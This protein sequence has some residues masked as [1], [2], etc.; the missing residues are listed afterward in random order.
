MAERELVDAIHHEVYE[1]LR[2]CGVDDLT[3]MRCAD[4]ACETL[5]GRFG[6]NRHYMP[7][8]DKEPRNLRIAADL[9][10]VQDPKA[11]ATKHGVSVSTVKRAAR[12]A[13]PD[14]GGFGSEDWNIK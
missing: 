1:A 5:Q 12:E 6:G 10:V 9:R 3:A 13:E 7:R 14:S 8:P 2:S 11:V 4:R